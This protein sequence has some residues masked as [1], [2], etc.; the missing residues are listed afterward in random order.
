MEDS[1]INISMIE[2][3]IEEFVKGHGFTG[4]HISGEGDWFSEEDPDPSVYEST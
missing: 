1:I 2:E 3:D 4:F